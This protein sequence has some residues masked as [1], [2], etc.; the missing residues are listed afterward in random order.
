MKEK[1]KYLIIKS[2]LNFKNIPEVKYKNIND[3]NKI[4]IVRLDEIGDVVLATPF[5]REL[6]KNYPNA[7]ITLIVKPQTYN[8][9]ELCPYVDRIL[10]FK[11]Y[12]GRFGFF[13][14]ILKTYSFAEKFLQK[15]KFDLAIIPRC[16]TDVYGASYLA[17]FS[18]AKC[19]VA[20][21]EKVS[22]IKAIEN[23]GFDGFFTDVIKETKHIHEVERNLDVIRYLGGKIND[24]C[25]EAYIEKGNTKRIP[26]SMQSLQ[27]VIATA[28]SSVEKEWDIEKYIQVINEIKKKFNVDVTLIGN[29]KRAEKQAD[30]L[31]QS[32]DI[33]NNLVNKTSLRESLLIL[34]NADIY[35][36]GDTGPTHLAASVGL[37]GIALFS[38]RYTPENY[39]YNCPERF[40]PWKSAID[41]LC[42]SNNES[43]V[44]G[45]SVD[46][47]CCKLE[48]MCS[49]LMNKEDKGTGGVAPYNEL[50][51]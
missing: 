9:V 14:N 27:F 39:G 24:D 4:L 2:I 43:G 8:L 50:E 41:V 12:Q 26:E 18:K 31:E 5:L 21:S 30:I 7:H 47:V 13:I 35:L 36:G 11:R 48:K 37:K 49:D 51:L 1:I 34:K 16:D 33:K 19:R 20:Y 32:C 40:G 10:T 17:Y 42:P 6:R 23:K 22:P 38:K 46:T 15:E 25:L 29:G 3:T 44:N 28:T 45:I